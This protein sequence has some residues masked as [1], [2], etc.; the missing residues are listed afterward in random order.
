MARIEHDIYRHET[1]QATITI[2]SISTVCSHNLQRIHKPA[3]NGFVKLR[4]TTTRVA[5]L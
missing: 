3:Y 2:S 4:E 1:D 5:S